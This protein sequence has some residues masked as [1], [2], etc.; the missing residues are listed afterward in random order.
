MRC[1]FFILIFCSLSLKAQILRDPSIPVS[2]EE[3]NRANNDSILKGKDLNRPSDSLKIYHPQITDYNVW[4]TNQKIKT[5][6]TA[7]TIDSFYKKNEYQKDLFHY[8][9]PINLGLALNPLSVEVNQA[10]F[11]ILPTGKTSMYKSVDKIK[12]YNV[13]TPLTQF[14]FETGLREGQYLS[15]TFTH[16]IHSRWNYAINYEYLSSLGNYLE[17][18]VKN[19]VLSLNSN[20]KTRNNRYQMQL[21]FV[22]HDLDNSEN[23]GLKQESIQAYIDNNP[24]FTNRQ[25]MFSN[26]RGAVSKFDERRIQMQHQFGILSFGNKKDTVATSKEFPIFLKHQ[27]VYKHQDFEY[28][29]NTAQ[30]FYDNVLVGTNLHNR[31]KLDNLTNKVTLGYKWSEKL[32]V[33]G[34]LIHQLIKP[35]NDSEWIYS[36]GVVPA[37]VVENRLGAVAD[38]VFN[39]KENIQVN[40]TGEMTQG[41]VFGNAYKLDANIALVPFKG[42]EFK[43]GVKLN[44][45][46]PSLN[47]FYNQSF[48]DKFNYYN[49]GLSN[50]ISQEVYASLS[51]DALGLNV[52]GKLL[53]I[54]NYT[55]LDE[56]YQV[57]QSNN[58]LSY[59]SI[60][61][62]EHYKFGKFGVDLRAEYQRVIE[63]ESLYP[64]PDIIARGTIYY[65][66]DA[67][68]KNMHF[69]TG[70]TTHYFSKFKSREFF[71]ILNEFNL[72]NGTEIGN[73]PQIDAFLNMKVRRMRIYL[74]T[75]NI[76]S[77]F[78]PGKNFYTPNLPSR[79]FKIQ[80]G[81]NWFLFS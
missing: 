32:N 6:D 26:M 45:N 2:I 43:G 50:E 56:A 54:D 73:Y 71:P 55:Y 78:M 12:Y 74:R 76:N 16:N 72:N 77:F 25:N 33:E 49:E 3:L 15:T 8:Q 62:R 59:F 68:N 37:S 75:Q 52:Y 80:I 24:N 42:Y 38:L 29:E 22:T 57:K 4:T 70:L 34:G 27:L 60:G 79:D 11:E 46:F 51:S 67:F 69:M 5:V 41:S 19:K 20:Y 66:N 17:T 44:S 36:Q 18:E 47:L 7:L 35:Y 48:Y 23:G 9:E 65:E 63:N 28:N 13:K 21:A 40:G 14:K 61:A 10:S 58:P 39:W 81:I 1:I 31:K 30:N 64:V 53:N